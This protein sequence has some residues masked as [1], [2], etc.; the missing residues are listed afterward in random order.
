MNP[1]DLVWAHKSCFAASEVHPLTFTK[2]VIPVGT[3]GLFIQDEP[4][5]RAVYVQIL[6][7][8][9]LVWVHRLYLRRAE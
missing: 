7:G 2:D 9:G 6:T 5:D 3:H 4:V 8:N 1:G